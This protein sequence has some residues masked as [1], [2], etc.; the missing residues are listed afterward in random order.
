MLVMSLFLRGEVSYLLVFFLILQVMQP[1]LYPVIIHCSKP[2]EPRGQPN[3]LWLHIIMAW[4]WSLSSI[5]QHHLFV[6]HVHNCHFSCL[7]CRELGYRHFFISSFFCPDPL[8]PFHRQLDQNVFL[9]FSSS[10]GVWFHQLVSQIKN[11]RNY[12]DTF[13]LLGSRRQRRRESFFIGRQI[14]E[15]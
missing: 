4:V 14:Y 11:R 12:R 3:Q 8:K 10:A 5:A 6:A 2:L 1:D 7:G 15:V 9:V 13:H